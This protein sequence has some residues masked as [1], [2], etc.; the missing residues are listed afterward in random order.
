MLNRLIYIFNNRASK[1]MMAKK[2]SRNRQIHNYTD[3]NISYP[4]INKTSRQ[5]SGSI[6]IH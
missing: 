2:T 6:Y 4:T 1:H 5:K 3:F